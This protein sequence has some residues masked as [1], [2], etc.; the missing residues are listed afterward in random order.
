MEEL[1]KY[2]RQTDLHENVAPYEI[3]NITKSIIEA[4][5]KGLLSQN[6]LREVIEMIL[7]IYMEQQLNEIIHK[8]SRKYERK[9]R[10]YN[11]FEEYTY[12]L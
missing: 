6:N 8:K 4:T 5:N 11:L 2:S 12:E 1:I 9:L 3:K 7:T 10:R